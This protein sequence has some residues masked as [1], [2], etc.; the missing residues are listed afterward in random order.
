MGSTEQLAGPEFLSC[1]LVLALVAGGDGD[2]NTD[3]HPNEP[4]IDYCNGCSHMERNR[5]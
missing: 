5:E 4:E 1:N 3:D 2:D